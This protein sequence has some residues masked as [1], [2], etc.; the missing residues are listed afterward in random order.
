METIAQLFI[1]GVMLGG[2]YAV[3]S[4]GLT[5]IFGVLKVVNFA[6]GE[7]IMLAMYLAW[8]V[9]TFSGTNAYASMLVV[10]PALFV[11][12]LLVYQLVIRP[13]IGPGAQALT[14]MP[15][16]PCSSAAVLLMPMM[17]C[18]EAT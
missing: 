3:M 12:G 17:A 6:H 14:R 5:L 15:R 4:I 2:I 18:F 10:I 11:F 13:A 8:A 9:V 1:S 16:A 7:F